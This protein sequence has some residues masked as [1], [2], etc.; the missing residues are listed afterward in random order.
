M[1]WT[2]LDDISVVYRK[3]IPIQGTGIKLDTPEAIAAWIAERKK[4][5]PTMQN[6]ADKEQKMREAVERDAISRLRKRT[7]A[8]KHG[9]VW[10]H[11]ERTDCGWYERCGG[12]GT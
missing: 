7:P 3:P 6:V 1:Y 8:H 2:R 5:F 10:M 12:A 9:L 11:A 4:R